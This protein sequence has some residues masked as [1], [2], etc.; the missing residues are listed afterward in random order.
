MT[1]AGFQDAPPPTPEQV[2][3]LLLRMLKEMQPDFVE[4]IPVLAAHARA[5]ALQLGLPFEAV[6]EITYAAELHD[7]GKLAIP[8]TMLTKPSALDEEEWGLMRRHTVIG[9]RML[10]AAPGLRPVAAIVRSSHERWDGEGYP[11]GLTADAIPL[12]GRLVAVADAFDILVH[13]RPYKEEWSEDD[14]AEEIRRNA[15]TQFDPD[16]VEAFD[17]LGGAAWKALATDI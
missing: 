5:T 13:E 11:D 8:E 3:D 1:F 16:V 9:E 2:R 6:D 4:H 14:A 7:I 17:E 15:A 10:A 12:A